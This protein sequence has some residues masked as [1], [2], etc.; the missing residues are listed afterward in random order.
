MIERFIEKYPQIDSTTAEVLDTIIMDL[1]PAIERQWKWGTLC[2]AINHKVFAY[3][4][5]KGKA[6]KLGLWNKNVISSTI[7]HR[8]LKLMGYYLIENL[9]DELLADLT[10]S[11]EECMAYRLKA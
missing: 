3:Y 6:I 9:N 7:I 5:L 1:H 2:Y 4:G 10:I 11:L 8:D